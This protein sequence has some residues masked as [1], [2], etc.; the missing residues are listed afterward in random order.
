M[1]GKKQ[2]ATKRKQFD[3]W[4]NQAEKKLAPSVIGA[5]H[6]G[7]NRNQYFA[8]EI[9]NFIPDREFNSWM[10]KS[11]F[12]EKV[13]IHKALTEERVV[14]SNYGISEHA[15]LRIFQRLDDGQYT[16]DYSQRK[17]LDELSFVPLWSNF[18]FLTLSQIK[19]RILLR[20]ISISI[21]TLNG[22]FL[23]NYDL[24]TSEIEIRTFIDDNL[25]S[26]EQWL[27]KRS[28]LSIG[29]YLNPSSLS[30]ACP[31]T[32]YIDQS[33]PHLFAMLSYLMYSN[34]NFNFILN[35]SIFKIEDDVARQGIKEELIF[36][37]KNFAKD[38]TFKEVNFLVSHSPREFSNYCIKNFKTI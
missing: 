8:F 18:W 13:I 2:T 4:A 24:E 37:I 7:S 10:E 3:K 33:I 19:S 20:E 9:L 12:G 16:S 1:L 5:Y 27:I 36:T 11:I 32:I 6:G 15:I 30:F 29:K 17:I 23:A 35:N 38:M 31:K 28:M 26:D 14:S 22:L 25:L 21:P 34:E